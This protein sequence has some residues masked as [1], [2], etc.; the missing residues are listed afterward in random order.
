MNFKDEAIDIRLLRES[1][2]EI[3]ASVEPDVFDEDV[4]ESLAAEFLDDPRHHIV[5]AIHESRVVGFASGIHYVHPDKPAELFI[6]ETG[7]AGRYRRQGI[8]SRLIRKLLTHARQ[9]GCKQAW[10]PT[11]TTNQAARALY[12]S[13][14]GEE[15][16][17]PT[18]VY[19][20]SLDEQKTA[21]E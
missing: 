3:L 1:D 15:D 13:L 8:A 9:L 17:E 18:I 11:E 2:G 4:V 5:V 6:T 7:V 12:R 20:F 19:N 10:V 14:G 21:S 16:P